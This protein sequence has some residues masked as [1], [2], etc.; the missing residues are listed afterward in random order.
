MSTDDTAAGD[1]AAG[2][3]SGDGP[4]LRI[5]NT[6]RESAAAALNAHLDAGRLGVE[7][8][9]DRSAI[10]A[11]ATTADELRALFVDLPAPHPELPHTGTALQAVGTGELATGDQG[12]V[13]PMRPSPFATWGP[14]IAAATPIIAVILF[15]A[16]RNVMPN[17]WLVF[18]LI[19][20]VGALGLHKGREERQEIERD[21]AEERRKLEGGPDA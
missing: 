20:L 10:A 14:R 19:P 17:A 7:E 13:A 11:N 1:G 18:L 2:G 3:R 8:Y 15:F 9:A 6:E 21:Q 12:V 16:L 5:G 4:A